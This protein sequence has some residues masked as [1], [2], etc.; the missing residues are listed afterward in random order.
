MPWWFEVIESKH[1]LQ[2]PTSV[3]KIRLLGRRLGLGPSSQVLDMAS[4]R[5]GPAA[6]LASSFG[7]RITCVEQSKGFLSAARDRGRELGVESLLDLVH[8]DGK[9]F[10]IEAERYD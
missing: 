1:E 2:N 10:P 9:A 3:D 7:C 5:G 4:G 8:S 6:I